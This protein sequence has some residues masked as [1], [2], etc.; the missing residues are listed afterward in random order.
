[1]K[2]HSNLLQRNFDLLHK[3]HLLILKKLCTLSVLCMICDSVTLHDFLMS[4]FFFPSNLTISE[5]SFMN[6]ISDPDLNLS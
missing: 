4:S 1:M 6:N 3:S 5:Y 2:S